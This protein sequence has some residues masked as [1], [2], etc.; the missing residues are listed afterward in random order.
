MKI[1]LLIFI[2]IFQLVL[3]IY[4]Y[5]SCK[6]MIVDDINE[7]QRTKFYTFGIIEGCFT[8]I[9]VLIFILLSYFSFS[10]IGLR[11]FD[12]Q[13]IGWINIVT[14]I[15]Y[16][17]L[18]LIFVYQMVMGIFS[19][20]YRDKVKEINDASVK[21]GNHYNV[22]I[23]KLILPRTKKE[24][25]L[26]S[27][28]SLTVGFSEEIVCR[29]LIV[30]LLQ[31]TF[32]GLGFIVAGLISSVLFAMMHMYQWILGTIKTGIFGFMFFMIYYVTG[33]L[34]LGIILHVIV[35]LSSTFILEKEKSITREE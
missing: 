7:K 3:A 12:F 15:L 8:L 18:L 23:N 30:F 26:Y 31:S 28:V 5:L 10:D 6:K 9:I 1:A 22:V 27:F 14:C 35:D 25:T 16:G 19:K 33:S 17:L 4:D 20:Q 13:S 34:I 29:G 2:V 11:S 32:P 21:K 24:K